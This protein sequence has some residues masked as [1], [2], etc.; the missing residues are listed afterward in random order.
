MVTA[1]Q[2]AIL[3]RLHET[4]RPVWV[5]GQGATLW[6]PDD[7]QRY[8][9]L[10]DHHYAF[11]VDLKDTVQRE[12]TAVGELIRDAWVVG[13][14][15]PWD[16]EEAKVWCICEGEG[17]RFPRRWHLWRVRGINLE[18]YHDAIKHLP[19]SRRLIALE[20]FARDTVLSRM[21]MCVSMG[22]ASLVPEE[23][24]PPEYVSGYDAIGAALRLLKLEE[25]V[26]RLAPSSTP[27]GAV[28][29]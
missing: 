23:V 8:A 17:S 9:F 27:P 1:R 14:G 19:D 6:A 26:Q 29:L 5:G 10:E 13:R 15:M 22:H 12:T 3:Q 18:V 21:H 24:L 7:Q 4:P 28:R 11:R 25:T 2:K 20:P 16:G